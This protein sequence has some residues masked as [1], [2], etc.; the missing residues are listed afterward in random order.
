MKEA[1]LTA[2]E[3]AKYLLFKAN[4]DGE[5]I[6]N[7][8]MQKLLYYAQAWYLVNYSVPLFA[9]PIKAWKFGPIVESAYH[10]FKR[11]RYS[12]I[13]FANREKIEEKISGKERKYLDDYYP[14]YIRHSAS[15]LTQMS[16]D[17]APWKSTVQGETIPVDVIMKFY[18]EQYKKHIEQK[19]KS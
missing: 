17:E 14:I 6:T 12:P 9:D 16:H 2:L 19:Q 8:K 15:D 10:H 3:V 11:F 13:Q 5:S 4:F 1:I 7:L 18:K